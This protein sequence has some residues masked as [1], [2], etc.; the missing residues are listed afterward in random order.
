MK[1][2]NLVIFLI[3]C[4][5]FVGFFHPIT[6]FTQDLGRH[7]KTGE[8]ILQTNTVP[9]T[10]LYS[11]TYPNYPF[12]NHHWLSEVVFY[13]I[14]ATLGAVGLQVITTGI[15]LLAFLLLL[16]AVRKQTHP[17]ALG[18][19]GLLYVRLLFERTDLRPEMFSF[20]FLSLFITILYQYRQGF[21]RWIFLLP[22]L[23]L[24]WVNTHIYF[25]VGIVVIGLFL[26][27]FF[28]S[29]RTH[30]TPQYTQ[31][32][33]FIFFFS[34][35]VTVINPNGLQGALYP[36]RVFQNYGYTIEENQQMFFLW[37]IG[38]RHAAY[39]TLGII[40][41]LLLTS[42]FFNRKKT[43]LIDW[44]LCGVFLLSCIIAVRNIPL[45]VF[46]TFIPFA[47][48]F[49]ALITHLIKKLAKKQATVVPFLLVGLFLCFVWQDTQVVSQKGFGLGVTPGAERAADFFLKN[50]LKGPIFNNFDI[51]SYLD[52]RFYPKEKV[53][54]DGRPEAYPASFLQ[55]TYIPMQETP[56]LFDKTVE[57]YHF[58]TIFFSHTDQ[59]PWAEKFLQTIM[60][61]ATWKPIYLDDTI[62]VFVKNTPQNQQLI[63]RF[64]I[65]DQS[66]KPSVSAQ[67]SFSSLLQL[68]RF[69][70]L[71]RWQNQEATMY[72]KLL[73]RD[74]NFCLALYNLAVL[75]AE[76]NNPSSQIYAGRFTQTCQ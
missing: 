7:I 71:V 32:L 24:L 8:I 12:I 62:I 45:F 17:L 39:I 25:F 56:T 10:N 76:Q 47:T 52:Y 1:V 28:F 22:L 35:L 48:H 5:L 72:Q 2:N 57:K 46:A 16:V 13:R 3:L 60:K 73:D 27:D 49:S 29:K 68:T 69:F 14:T 19:A 15:V 74:P 70:N 41:T 50:N 66:F 18:I 67:A 23:E 34:C 11:Y 63:K 6:A 43:A 51:G 58:N 42:L 36:L 20:L 37:G 54:V 44:L 61:N 26:I 31:I 9:K 65:S 30:R 75:Y 4:L 55:Q 59:T 53:F 64:G 38:L 21:T 40:S 33:F